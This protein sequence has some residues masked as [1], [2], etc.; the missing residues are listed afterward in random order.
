MARALAPAFIRVGGPESD[1]L[2]FTNT[3]EADEKISISG[4]HFK[5]SFKCNG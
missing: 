4:K 3:T 1:L 5:D 2:Q